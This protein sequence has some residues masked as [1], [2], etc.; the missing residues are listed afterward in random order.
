MTTTLQI[1]PPAVLTVT[2]VYLKKSSIYLLRPSSNN[3]RT[4]RKVPTTSRFQITKV[5]IKIQEL[6]ICRYS[7]WLSSLFI[8]W[9]G[10]F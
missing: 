8:W 4:L 7:Y 2:G 10:F 6:A 5:M 3:S 9:L 1:I